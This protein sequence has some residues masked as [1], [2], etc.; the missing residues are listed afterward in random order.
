MV[1]VCTHSSTPNVTITSTVVVIASVSAPSSL[2]FHLAT[3]P[4]PSLNR[5]DATQRLSGL[6]ST[7]D[8]SRTASMHLQPP[9]PSLAFPLP[10]PSHSLHRAA[11]SAPVS[12]PQLLLAPPPVLAAALP[13]LRPPHLVRCHKNH[14]VCLEQAAD[15]L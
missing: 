6:T 3:A 7:A 2:L 11:W 12:V 14:L 4:L 5:L 13:P 15:G 8:G 10:P 9:A 1:C